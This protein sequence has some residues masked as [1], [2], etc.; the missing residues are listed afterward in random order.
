MFKFIIP[1]IILVIAG[2]L[3]FMFTKPV[4]STIDDIKA[5]SSAY[6]E[7][8]KNAKE[9]QSIRDE[10]TSKYNSFSPTDISK[11]KTMLPDT[12]DTVQL[13]IDLDDMAQTRGLI[14]R[15]TK[16]DSNTATD[17]QKTPTDLI[18]ETKNYETSN[19]GFTVEGKYENFQNFLRDLEQS[20][21]LVEVESLTFSAAPIG[22][23][24]NFSFHVDLSTYWLRNR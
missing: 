20:L 2:G 10:L 19:I 21:R 4:Y 18:F 6:D 5:R 11:I 17:G 14:F 22:K 24:G 23:T 12:V 9:L 15:D 3:F 8:L 13:I 7:A 16:F 1:T